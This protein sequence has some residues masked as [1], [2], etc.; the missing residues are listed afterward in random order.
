MFMHMRWYSNLYKE[1]T[2]VFVFWKDGAICQILVQVYILNPLVN[3][4][5]YLC[6]KSS[7][8]KDKKVSMWHRN[9]SQSHFVSSCGST[10]QVMF[11]FCEKAFGFEVFVIPACLLFM[12]VIHVA[13]TA[14]ENVGLLRFA[15]VR[16]VFAWS[17]MQLFQRIPHMSN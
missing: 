12:F 9:S 15:L 1:V 16:I 13:N 11:Y 4:C 6:V 3:S 8:C 14:L 2:H 17:R 7:L 10:W 5:F